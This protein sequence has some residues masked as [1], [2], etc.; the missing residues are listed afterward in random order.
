VRLVRLF[1]GDKAL[2]PLVYKQ[3]F[4]SQLLSKVDEGRYGGDV[5]KGHKRDVIRACMWMRLRATKRC[6]GDVIKC[7]TVM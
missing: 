4:A 5:I 1:G 6:Y 3:T 7:H 2:K